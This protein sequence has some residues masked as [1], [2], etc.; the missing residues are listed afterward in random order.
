MSKLSET[1]PFTILCQ[2]INQM[3]YRKEHEQQEILKYYEVLTYYLIYKSNYRTTQ[4]RPLRN[5]PIL[6]LELMRETLGYSLEPQVL[7]PMRHTVLLDSLS[8]CNM[9]YYLA[10][11]NFISPI[12][13]LG[14]SFFQF[15]G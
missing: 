5:Q 13:N 11:N 1:H 2:Y 3:H 4:T 9:Y 10:M 14:E 12:A 6:S 8:F 7:L 15:S